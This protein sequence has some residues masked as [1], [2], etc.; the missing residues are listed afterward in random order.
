MSNVYFW[1]DLHL[2]HVNI[3]KFRPQFKDEKDHFEYIKATWK[4][5]VNKHDKVFILGD[6]CFTTEALREFDTWAGRKVLILGNHDTDRKL[7]MRDLL[8]SYDEIHSLYKHKEFW[9]SH[10][11]IHQ[12]ELRGKLNIHGHTHE[13][14][15]NDKRYYNACVEYN[16]KPVTIDKIRATMYSDNYSLL[17][18][19]AIDKQET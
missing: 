5:T 6:C 4:A 8:Y 17:T 13:H 11:P 1:S 16:P 2:G 19:Q 12:D 9:L 7:S 18:N 14:V 15:V 10:C 3:H